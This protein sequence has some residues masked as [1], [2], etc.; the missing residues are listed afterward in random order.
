MCKD[1]FMQVADAMAAHIAE[2]Q[3]DGQKEAAIT[4]HQQNNAASFCL[5]RIIA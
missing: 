1:I 4:N 3:S 5:L 2:Q